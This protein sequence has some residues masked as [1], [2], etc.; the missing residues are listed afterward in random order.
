MPIIGGAAHSEHLPEESL[1]A[2]WGITPVVDPKGGTAGLIEFLQSLRS[3][4]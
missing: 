4:A 1:F 3:T 2:K